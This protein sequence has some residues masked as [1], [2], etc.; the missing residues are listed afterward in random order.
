MSAGRNTFSR[1]INKSDKI[2][3]S[4]LFCVLMIEKKMYS[5][6][7]VFILTVMH[8]DKATSYSNTI[9]QFLGIDQKEEKKLRN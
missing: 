7:K 2:Y 3:M 6:R 4:Y 5:T 1:E 8:D 9:I